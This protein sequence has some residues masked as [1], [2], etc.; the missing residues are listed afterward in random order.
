MEKEEI[1]L[2]DKISLRNVRHS[3]KETSADLSLMRY[4]VSLTDLGKALIIAEE[5]GFSCNEPP[6]VV[7]G[8]YDDVN[9]VVLYLTKKK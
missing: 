9:D 7:F 1:K 3:R 6:S 4:G 2:T 8:Y 5:M